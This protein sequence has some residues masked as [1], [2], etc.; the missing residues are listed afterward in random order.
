MKLDFAPSAKTVAYIPKICLTI[1]VQVPEM[2]D[3]NKN[4]D[5]DVVKT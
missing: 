5:S 1:Y 3:I 2:L 4:I